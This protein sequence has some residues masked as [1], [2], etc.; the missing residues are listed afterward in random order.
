MNGYGALADP[1]RRSINAQAIVL[2]EAALDAAERQ[3]EPER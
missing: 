3:R 1:E 2:L